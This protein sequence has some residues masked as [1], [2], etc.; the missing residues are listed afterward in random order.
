MIGAM[1]MKSDLDI[2]REA[3]LDPIEKVAARAGIEERCIEPYGRDVAKV[4]LEV[5]KQNR[6]RPRGKYVV[7]TA[8][9][10]TP[11]GEGKTTTAVGLAQGLEKIGKRSVLASRAVPLAPGIPK[12]CRWRSSTCT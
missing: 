7:V 9:T 5:I 3:H 10:P 1:T 4:D 8:I 2:A 12:C 11:L 6:D